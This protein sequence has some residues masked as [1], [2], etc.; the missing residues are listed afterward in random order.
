MIMNIGKLVI[1]YNSGANLMKMYCVWMAMIIGMNLSGCKER[2]SSTEKTADPAQDNQQKEVNV[3]DL[4]K[5]IKKLVN[6][7]LEKDKGVHLHAAQELLAIGEPAY[8]ALYEAMSS[9]YN[10]TWQNAFQAFVEIGPEAVPA[11]LAVICL[12]TTGELRH[13]GGAAVILEMGKTALPQLEEALK[14][15][16]QEVRLAAIW[17]LGRQAMADGSDF[18]S[19][20]GERFGDTALINVLKNHDDWM[21]RMAAAEGLGIMYY[22][23]QPPEGVVTALNEA[24]QDKNKEVQNQVAIAISQIKSTSNI[25][26]LPTLIQSLKSERWDTRYSA[27]RALR[28]MGPFAEPAISALEEI[29]EGEDGML[30]E[31]AASILAEIGSAARPVLLKALKSSRTEV[32]DR[33]AKVLPPDMRLEASSVATDLVASLKD[34][35]KEVRAKAAQALGKL[36]AKGEIV[37]PALIV[38]LHDEDNTVR[39]SA[40]EALEHFGAAAKKA[41]PELLAL[42]QNEDKAKD[43][44][45]F[46]AS[47]AASAIGGMGPV[48]GNVIPELEKY[49]E[50]NPSAA[51]AALGRIG[52]T[53][54]STLRTAL[55]H[56]NREVRYYAVRAMHYLGPEAA[57]AVP[58]LIVSMDDQ[59]EYMRS[60]SIQALGAIGP[61]AIAATDKLL[62]DIK[63]NKSETR[64]HSAK[65][66]G[67]IGVKDAITE[68]IKIVNDGDIKGDWE[69]AVA[70]VQ[71]GESR[72]AV[73]VFI[74]QLEKNSNYFFPNFFMI[75]NQMGPAAQEAE[76]IITKML[77]DPDR[78]IYDKMKYAKTLV[79]ID[80]N[81]KAGLEFLEK[82]VEGI[83]GLEAMTILI[84]TGHVNEGI[85]TKLKVMMNDKYEHTAIQ[86]AGVLS[87]V[88]SEQEEATK[89]LFEKLNAKDFMDRFLAAAA[90]AEAGA[91]NEASIN[92]LTM[93]ISSKDEFNDY[94]WESDM[95]IESLGELG[96]K[97]TSAIPELEKLLSDRDEKVRWKALDTIKQINK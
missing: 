3:K 86:S 75:L 69:A 38:A 52:P 12:E 82:Q 35:D 43:P 88:D 71:L 84:E 74:E 16:N 41:I 31:E 37:I 68:L 45:G 48:A 19:G 13:N 87:K 96:T 27:L 20:K 53:T 70:L 30:G 51:A 73:P 32:R 95:A 39:Q 50:K 59:G 28:Q 76:E 62:S 40:A 7:F 21:T 54:L 79:Y 42:M 8:Q 2:N 60:S 78:E 81:S 57:E 49:L 4:N 72:A 77:N 47:A 93:M 64:F 85:I 83:F 17:I 10:P 91:A 18:L 66:L 94:T 67:N 65:T 25:S 5:Q 33:V 1:R 55:K 29:L 11:M 14:N 46:I 6:L 89:I 22:N 15:E 24:L 80:P 61:A 44:Y 56:D 97:A 90:L 26:Y 9:R 92:I 63:S 23:K 58:D 36:G 34:K